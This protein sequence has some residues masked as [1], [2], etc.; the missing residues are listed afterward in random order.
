MLFDTG[1]AAQGNNPGELAR[2][3]KLTYSIRSV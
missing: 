3:V 1:Y 2:N